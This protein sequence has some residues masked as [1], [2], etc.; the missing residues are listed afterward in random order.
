M[1]KTSEPITSSKDQS[2]YLLAIDKTNPNQ[3]CINSIKQV[4]ITCK[5][6]IIEAKKTLGIF[7]SEKYQ[8]HVIWSFKLS[9]DK[10]YFITLLTKIL[11]L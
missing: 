6:E 1:I 7:S 3:Y 2:E 4:F 5:K 10:E 11:I 9:H 8:N